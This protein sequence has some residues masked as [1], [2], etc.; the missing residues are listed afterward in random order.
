[1]KLQE[2]LCGYGD[3]KC[4]ICAALLKESGFDPDR[5]EHWI[6]K[7]LSGE[8]DFPQEVEAK[9]QDA[10]AVA[11]GAQDAE[12][13]ADGNGASASA[14]NESAGSQHGDDETEQS[15]GDPFAWARSLAPDIVLLTSRNIQQKVSISMQNLYDSPPTRRKN[16]GPLSS[17]CQEHQALLAKPHLKPCTPDQPAT[18]PSGGGA[19]TFARLPSVA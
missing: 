2:R 10:E 7:S 19:K 8:S 13:S 3:I 9:D 15:S 14:P 16:R 12:A 17:P 1:M 18:V 5:L 4:E 11:D 6:M